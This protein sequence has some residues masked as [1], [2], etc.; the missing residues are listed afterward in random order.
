MKSLLLPPAP[1]QIPCQSSTITLSVSPLLLVS[2]FIFLKMSTW[3]SAETGLYCMYFFSYC[4][5]YSILIYE[6]VQF[7]FAVQDSVLLLNSI[8]WNV[9]GILSQNPLSFLL[10]RLPTTSNEE[11]GLFI[12]PLSLLSFYPN[13]IF[14]PFSWG[15]KISSKSTTGPG[16]SV[17]FI[18]NHSRRTVC[19]TALFPRDRDCLGASVL[20]LQRS[21]PDQCPGQLLYWGF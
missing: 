14:Y 12:V 8:Y 15:L 16:G 5:D 9:S 19:V 7:C 2:W 10:H 21:I 13:L 11:N 1:R 4:R 20:M 17:W 18:F 3:E 6:T